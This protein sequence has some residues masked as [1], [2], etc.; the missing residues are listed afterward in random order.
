M[1]TI[2]ISELFLKSPSS[3]ELDQLASLQCLYTIE[4]QLIILM[5]GWMGR[6]AKVF[7]FGRNPSL[8][9]TT[10]ARGMCGYPCV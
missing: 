9:W 8:A 7:G 1:M 2:F 10:G 5:L 3:Q 4:V 6:R